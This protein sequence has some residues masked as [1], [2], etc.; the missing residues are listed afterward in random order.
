MRTSGSSSL[1]SLSMRAPIASRASAAST[2]REANARHASRRAHGL[3]PATAHFIDAASP[4][5]STPSSRELG[6][7]WVNACGRARSVCSCQPD[8]RM[9]GRT[10]TR[11]GSAV[12]P[13]ALQRPNP[14][15]AVSGD[16][17]GPAAVCG[18]FN[19]S[20]HSQHR[21]SG[22]IY[23]AFH[24]YIC[25]NVEATKP[26][27]RRSG[28]FGRRTIVDRTAVGGGR[29]MACAPAGGDGGLRA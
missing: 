1:A 17:G 9:A 2:A 19:A 18:R 11:D 22:C 10:A 16:G 27:P 25:G 4:P 20:Q 8:L 15:R 5:S 7:P 28:R 3:S 26:A 12:A 6:R 24:V 13:N 21:L 29:P 14:G 23:I